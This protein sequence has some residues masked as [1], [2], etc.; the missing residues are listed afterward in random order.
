MRARNCRAYKKDY[1][2][3]GGCGFCLQ[4]LSAYD[5]SRIELVGRQ[6]LTPG[7]THFCM[8]FIMQECLSRH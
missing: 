5:V 4:F 8:D 2:A 6:I 7:S 1:N 3:A